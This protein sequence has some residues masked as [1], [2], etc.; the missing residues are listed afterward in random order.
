MGDI[1]IAAPVVRATAQTNPDT[2]FT[3]VSRPYIE[4]LFT[5]IP[6]LRFY[7]VDFTGRL[8]G[9]PGLVRL[10]LSLMK[11]NPTHIADLHNVTRTWILRTLF[12]L[13]FVPVK[14]MKKGRKERRLLTRR[15]N[16]ILKQITPVYEKYAAVL[17]RTG[18]VIPENEQIIL[19]G[20]RKYIFP[21]NSAQKTEDRFIKIGIA[22][23][24]KHK[25]KMWPLERMEQVISTLSKNPGI[26]IF[27][28]GGGNKE[29]AMLQAMEQKYSS[30]ESMA[31][32]HSLSKEIEIIRE[33]DLLVTMDSANMH[34]ASFA[35]TPVISIWGATHPFAGFYGL[36]QPQEYAVQVPLECRP[37]SVYGNKKCYRKDYAC[38]MNIQVSD[39][40]ERVEGFIQKIKDEEQ[41][42]D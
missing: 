23:F 32:R 15:D 33:L 22:P 41:K 13:S 1:A 2:F 31:G 5:G 27:L 8:K 37:C 19:N 11:L 36:G 40:L 10:F 29:S 7:P 26:K 39:V 42:R 12:F 3:M 30:V 20:G 38:L 21:D 18:I 16:K 24:A 28:F 14:Y 6:N 35:S 25:A 17:Q 34:L 9:I 4:P